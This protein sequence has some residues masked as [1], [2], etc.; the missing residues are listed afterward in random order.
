MGMTNKECLNKIAKLTEELKIAD[1]TKEE[2]L[3]AL[4][5]ASFNEI[6]EELWEYYCFI[7]DIKS[8]LMEVEN[9]NDD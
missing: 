6:S 5:D 9:G 3:E 8:A 7:C 4:K 1:V 2:Y